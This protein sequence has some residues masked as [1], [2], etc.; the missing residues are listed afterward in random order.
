MTTSCRSLSCPHLCSY[1]VYCCKSITLSRVVGQEKKKSG[2]TPCNAFQGENDP[3]E[4]ATQSHLF[5]I[6]FCSNGT[7][8]VLPWE[9]YFLC[10]TCGF[11]QVLFSFTKRDK[12]HILFIQSTL[13]IL[14]SVSFFSR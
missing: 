6:Y 9:T 7:L 13:T 10:Y 12:L 5:E 11:K 14:A 3:N 1:S 8:V 2:W 4:R